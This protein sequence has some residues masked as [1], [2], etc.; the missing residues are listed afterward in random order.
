VLALYT[1]YFA[2]FVLL[3]QN[4][5]ALYWLWRSGSKLWRRWLLAQL[6]I[7]LLFSPWLP[8]LYHQVSTGGGG[9]VERS[10]GRP[11]LYALVDTWL[12]FSI[13]LDRQFYPVWLRRV[14]YLLFAISN[15]AAILS[16]FPSSSGEARPRGHRD[17]EG[18]LFCLA[19]VGLPLL[20]VWLL[21]QLKPMYSIRFLLVF[22]PPYYILVAKGIDSLRWDW[23]RA[24]FA[25]ALTVSLLVGNWNA[26]RT[27][28]NPDW[29][30]LTSYILAQAQPGDTVLFSP[31]WNEKP[32]TYY[33]RGRI[34]VN[35][36]LPTPVTMD[37]AQQV[38]EDIYQQHQR[39]WLVWTR[40]H[41]S[42]PDGIVKQ[43]LERRYGAA[44]ER[45]FRG[46]DRLILYD[47]HPA[48]ADTNA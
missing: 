41:Y 4:L 37:A 17:R 9:W 10:V 35:T 16:V 18:V 2:L 3:L 25:L 1:H 15:L 21:S 5:F 14:A 34:D 13:G 28:Q 24:A 12:H 36:D 32:F 44:E 48:E 6:V 30:G 46:V 33:S 26:W 22:L 7:A 11:S 40:G 39:V 47:L 38:V 43:I 29:R 8:V 45:G 31:R 23:A 20:T 42:D 19:Y 27:E